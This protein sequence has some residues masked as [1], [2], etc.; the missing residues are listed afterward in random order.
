MAKTV[1]LSET[2]QEKIRN[3]AVE[4]NKKLVD[5]M[6]QPLKDSELVH[7]ILEEA[8]E[9]LEVTKSGKVIIN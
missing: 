4:I 2:E 1:R 5:Q 6:K 8:I 9:R 7:V 3:K